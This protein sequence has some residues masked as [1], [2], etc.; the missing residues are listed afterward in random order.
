MCGRADLWW[1]GGLP[2][3]VADRVDASMPNWIT[4]ELAKRHTARIAEVDKCVLSFFRSFVRS[5]VGGK[6]RSE[7]LT[8]VTQGAHPEPE[9][10]RLPH[11]PRA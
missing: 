8:V 9:Q 2:T 10:D 5:F 4:E 1:E 11:A 6:R 7:M 3:D